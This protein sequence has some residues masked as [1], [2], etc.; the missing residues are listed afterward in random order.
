MQ[1]QELTKVRLSRKAILVLVALV[2]AGIGSFAILGLTGSERANGATSPT[3][4]VDA[5]SGQTF[6]RATGRVLGTA[7]RITIT[8]AQG[9]KAEVAQSVATLVDVAG[10]TV[11]GT[12]DG[13]TVLVGPARRDA[14]IDGDAKLDGQTCVI[15]NDDSGGAG[16]QVGCGSAEQLDQ[17]GATYAYRDVLAGEVSGASLLPAGAT[18]PTLNGRALPSGDRVITFRVAD[19][20]AVVITFVRDG[21]LESTAIPTDVWR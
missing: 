16:G 5:A 9:N 19:S 2:G 14:S 21:K 20:E 4:A 17:Q 12:G 8:D 15:V 1:Q 13:L 18:D 6:D 3:T 10:T 7:P 11:A